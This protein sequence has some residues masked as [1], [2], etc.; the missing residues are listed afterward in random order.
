VGDV[1]TN[2]DAA[3]LANHGA[4]AVGED[5]ERAFRKIEELELLCK[6]ITVATI[7]GGVKKISQDKLNLLHEIVNARAKRQDKI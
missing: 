6:M 2:H 1:I 4:I 7:M 3:L 5:L